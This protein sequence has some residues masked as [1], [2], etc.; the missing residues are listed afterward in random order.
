MQD[1]I[2][3]QFENL[4][5]Y[6]EVNMR[7]EIS[8]LS[9]SGQQLD[10]ANQEEGISK[11]YYVKCKIL[12]SI[13]IDIHIKAIIDPNY[14]NRPESEKLKNKFQLNLQ[15]VLELESFLGWH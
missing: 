3:F 8:E 12:V 13:I 10:R 6:K 15:R 14:E 2:A 11:S 7:F 5:P 1:Y 9:G 4:I